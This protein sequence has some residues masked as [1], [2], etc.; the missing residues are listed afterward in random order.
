MAKFSMMTDAKETIVDAAK[1]GAE[2]VKTVAGEALGA[3]AAAAAGVVLEHMSN[4]LAA[5]DAKIQEATPAATEAARQAVSSPF[6]KSGAKKAKGKRTAKAI[7][8]VR[9]PA[10]KK[11]SLAKTNKRPAKRKKATKAKAAVKRSAKKRAV[12]KSR[13]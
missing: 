5:G 13:R 8:A 3:A 11:K 2:G 4:A 7:A 1:A 9:K 6:K 12:R 10:A